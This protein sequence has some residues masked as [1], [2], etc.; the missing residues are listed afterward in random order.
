MPVSGR[1]TS[2]D[3]VLRVLADFRTPEA[4]AVVDGFESRPSDVFICTYP[5]CGT[6]LVQQIVHQLRSG[7][8]MDFDEIS[9]VV[10][11]IE[12]ALD[13]GIDPSADQPWE[14]RAFKSHLMWRDVPRG[15][16]YITVFR[17]PREVLP[18]F[19]R[20]FEGWMFAS[21]SISIDDFARGLYL[22]GSASGRHW[23]HFVDW[24]PR[25]HDSDV[26]ALAY[27]DIVA[28]PAETTAVIADFIEI[29]PGPDT[30]AT[31]IRQS[32]RSFMLERPTQFDDHT[33]RVAREPVWGLPA[34]GDSD[35][36]T[37]GSEVNL[38]DG[39]LA[40]LDAMWSEVVTP[41]LG[42]ASYD[43][44]RDALPGRPGR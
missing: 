38:S 35:K 3:G 20:F 15:G 24:W 13:I 31:A 28:A 10:P 8:S 33:L 36:V 11:W 23:D 42:F 41:A 16:R 32:S 27:E 39:L 6:T 5:K 44:L 29:D 17:D 2:V 4:R 21:G 9:D 37:A 30:V 14:P 40:E 34:G 12:S 1:P 22:V 18:S 7:G 19:Y 25:V 43:E 26:L